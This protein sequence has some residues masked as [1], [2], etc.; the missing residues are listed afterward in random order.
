VSKMVMGLLSCVGKKKSGE[1][2]LR[3]ESERV[4]E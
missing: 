4:S 2:E 1:V 3:I